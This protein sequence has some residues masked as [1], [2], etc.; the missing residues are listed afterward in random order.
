MNYSICLLDKGGRTRRTA[1]GPYDDDAAALA[2]AHTEIPGSAMVE[3]WKE[4]HLL[5]R[6]FRDP[7]V[8]E[9]AQ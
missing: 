7:P 2:H 6:L 8:P 3:V 9:T 1:Y 5:A 4:E